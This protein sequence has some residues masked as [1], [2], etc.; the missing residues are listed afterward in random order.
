MGELT[1]MSAA[2]LVPIE[3][4]ARSGKTTQC[5]PDEPVYK[6]SASRRYASEGKPIER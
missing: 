1:S 2:T 4:T 5:G 3:K 6:E